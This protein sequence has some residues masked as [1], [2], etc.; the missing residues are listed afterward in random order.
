MLARVQSL[1]AIVA[2]ARISVLR[3]GRFRRVQCLEREI[4]GEDLSRCREEA[5]R[6]RRLQQPWSDHGGRG[7]GGAGLH[8]VSAI[9]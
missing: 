3:A 6:V 8:E 2:D 7:C 1:S 9:R 5:A 4:V